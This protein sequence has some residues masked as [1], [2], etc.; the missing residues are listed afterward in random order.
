[1]P[2]R[3]CLDGNQPALIFPSVL[4]SHALQRLFLMCFSMRAAPTDGGRCHSIHVIEWRRIPDQF[5]FSLVH[6]DV[7]VGQSSARWWWGRKVVLRGPG[8]VALSSPFRCPAA[9]NSG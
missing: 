7:T 4:I 8:A 9:S 1:V 6:Y 2:A 3:S 5:I